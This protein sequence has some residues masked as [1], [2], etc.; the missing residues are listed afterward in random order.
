MPWRFASRAT[1]AV[2]PG[3]DSTTEYLIITQA[4]KKTPASGWVVDRKARESGS[5]L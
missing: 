1:F 2:L 4:A 3:G 5:C